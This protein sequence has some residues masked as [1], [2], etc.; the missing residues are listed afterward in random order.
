[1]AEFKPRFSEGRERRTASSPP[2]RRRT[3]A[4]SARTSRGSLARCDD[5]LVQRFKG[6][7]VDDGMANKSINNVLTALSV[8]LKRAV[9]WKVIEAMPCRIR[10][11]QWDEGEIA[12]Y[13]LPG[14]V[15]S[16]V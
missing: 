9:D 8:M 4:S 2:A 14:Q 15:P 13:D 3:R 7:L 6:E 1:M 10:L 11:L 12:F 5:E 16:C